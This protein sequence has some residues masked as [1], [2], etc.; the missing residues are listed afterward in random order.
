M[1]RNV[2]IK[3]G[4]QP[5]VGRGLMVHESWREYTAFQ[6]AGHLLDKELAGSCSHQTPSKRMRLMSALS[7]QSKK[8]LIQHL[9]SVLMAHAKTNVLS[10]SPPASSAHMKEISTGSNTN[11]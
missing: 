1:N 5:M 4:S 7:T 3:L 2:A 9:M 11:P 8:C 10:W 6:S